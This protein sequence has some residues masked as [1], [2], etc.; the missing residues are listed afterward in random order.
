MNIRSLFLILFLVVTLIGCGERTINPYEDDEGIFSIYGA[1]DVGENPNVIRIRNLS[2]PL[3]TNSSF[4]L[5]AT[6]TFKNLQTGSETVLNDSIVHFPAGRTHNFILNENLETD[7][8]YQVTVERSDGAI[9]QAIVTTPGLTEVSYTP[10]D[11][12][13][14]EEPMQIQFDNVEPPEFIKMEVGV[15]YQGKEHWAPVDLVG[16]FEYDINQDMMVMDIRPRNLLVNIFTPPLPDIP[17][18][19][20]YLLFPTVL[21]DELDRE[22]FMFRYTH[23]G[24][25]WDE[26]LVD[27]ETPID[28]ETGFV[29]NGLGFLGAYRRGSFSFEFVPDQF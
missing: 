12:F 29:E 20:T 24:P 6:V 7:S 22:L 5:D 26:V 15:L 13:Y 2:E 8:Q 19:N 17:N 28:I 21:C 23:F 3:Q 11:I 4:P 18:F 1:L 14:C 10:L 16:E 25:D 9:S 27:E